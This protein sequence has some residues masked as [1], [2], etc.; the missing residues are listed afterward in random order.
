MNG[1]VWRVVASHLCPRDHLAAASVCK[2]LEEALVG[3]LSVPSDFPFGIFACRMRVLSALRAIGARVL[4]QTIAYRGNVYVAES[5][6]GSRDDWGA[7][8]A[9]LTPRH[10]LCVAAAVVY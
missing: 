4:N 5:P 8:V 9:A 7:F 10:A 3:V 2:S 6:V 1:D